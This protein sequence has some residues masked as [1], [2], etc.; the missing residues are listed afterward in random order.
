MKPADEYLIRIALE[1]GLLRREQVPTYVTIDA[2][3]SGSVPAVAAS[4]MAR[5]LVTE[6]ILNGPALARAVAKEFDL[7]YV[8]LGGRAVSAEV[9][10]ALPRNFVTK[11]Q[12]FPF[13]WA[14]ENLLVALAD[15]LDV[16]LLDSLAH[17][18]GRPVTAC[19]ATEEDIKHAIN[20][21]YGQPV[22]L[23][24]QLVPAEA[25]TGIEAAHDPGEAK[26]ADAPIIK[27]VHDIILGA[28]HQRASDIHLEP[29]ER[30]FRVRYRIDGVL[31]G[32]QCSGPTPCSWPSSRG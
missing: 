6:G 1:H 27:M 16:V 12:A 32:G 14:G 22:H 30:R 28:V 8:E 4:N 15:P 3:S 31:H 29:L 18:A 25:S 21:H 20:R 11:H 10:A 2:R 26:A 24:D 23:I 5:Q 17:V 13:G 9:L 7:S 19:V